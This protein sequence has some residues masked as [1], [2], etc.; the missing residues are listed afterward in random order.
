MEGCR[1]AGGEGAAAWRGG[2]AERVE[3]TASQVPGQRSRAA[4]HDTA[5]HSAARHNTQLNTAR[6]SAAQRATA[7]RSA[8]PECQRRERGVPARRPAVDAEALG[9]HQAL[10]KCKVGKFRVRVGAPAVIW[11]GA[12]TH[13]RTQPPTRCHPPPTAPLGPGGARHCSSR[14]CPPRPTR[15]PGAA[16]TRGRSRWSRLHGAGHGQAGRQVGTSRRQWQ[17]AV[18]GKA[19][20]SSCVDP[21]CYGWPGPQPGPLPA[22]ARLEA[23]PARP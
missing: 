18:N 14:Q 15:P 2:Q 6:R 23:P 5:Q 9:V 17:G 16:G 4:G 12:A 19:P 21:A 1:R 3:G 13:P 7:Q 22:D 10:Q 20:K 8:A 11:V